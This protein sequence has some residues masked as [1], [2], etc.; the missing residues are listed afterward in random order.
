MTTPKLKRSTSKLGLC[1]AALV[2]SGLA[3]G[4][5]LPTAYAEPLDSQDEGL[6][7]TA[8]QEAESSTW[9]KEVSFPDWRGY[10]DDTL[11]MNSRCAFLGYHD[12]GRLRVSVKDGVTGFALYVNGA[13]TDTSKR[14]A[15]GVYEVDIAD[16]AL[17]GTNSLQ[18]SNITPFALDDAVTVSIPYPE[19]L[20]GVPEREGISA[21]SLA[22]ISDLIESD[23]EHGFAAAQLAIVRNGRLVYEGAWGRTNSYLSDGTPNTSSPRV[24]STTLFELASNSKMY[25]VNYALQKLVSDGAVSLDARIADFLGREFVDDTVLAHD[26][27]G[28]LP[29]AS[30]ADIKRWKSRLTIRDLLRHQ[31]GFPADPKYP[32]PALYK[33][34]LAEGDAYQE[35]DLYAGAGPTP[36]H[37]RRPSRRSARRRSTTSP[38]PGPS[39]PTWTTWS[40]V[41]SWKR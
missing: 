31:E 16:V 35:N 3:L 11:A 27:D 22:M 39:A 18:V 28:N 8:Q 12:Q 9:Q 30:L 40:W 4:T 2:A 19:V 21:Q 23:V 1:M 6:A 5:R 26:A 41:S 10:I 29:K 7:L 33:K 37:A 25:A 24:T 14:A 36:R 13:R 38:G 32:M 34:D 17:D 20:A 15:G